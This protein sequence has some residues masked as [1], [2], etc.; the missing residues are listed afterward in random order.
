M[1][2]QQQYP[3]VRLPSRGSRAAPAGRDG[4]NVFQ[5]SRAP[6]VSSDNE[7]TDR[8]YAEASLT[9]AP[10]TCFRSL[11]VP[12]DGKRFGEHALPYA[13]GI[14]R[15]SGADIRLVHVHTPGAPP[16]SSDLL[17][18]GHGSGT[19]E[20]LQKQAYLND[21]CQ[22]VQ[23]ITPVRVTSLLVEGNDTAQSLYQV[24]SA[25]SDLVV[26]ASHGR[27]P[28]GRFCF[29]STGDALLQRLSVPVL[30]VR[31]Y[32]APV[33]LTGNPLLHHVL[34][35]LD[36]SE[37][38]E[39]VLDPALTLGALTGA[40]HTLIR[41]VRSSSDY[42][43]ESAGSVSET[44]LANQQR[45]DAWSYLQRV[46]DQRGG[47]M[48]RIHPRLVFDEQSTA[49]SILSFAE[50]HHADLI[51]LATSGRRGFE[52]LFRGSVADRVLRGATAPVLVINPSTGKVRRTIE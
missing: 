38:A 51:A 3:W 31:G 24:A 20:R 27:G 33:D 41:V 45:L 19:F 23:K 43:D 22:R 30:F 25:G 47:L 52:R 16:H 14:A 4:Q 17:Y 7:T 39:Q 40:E 8:A 32:K 29:G 46:A 18:Y 49:K 12:V 21:L 9:V 11:L 1:K 36:G 35:P 5:L 26:M 13:L 50:V 6:S 37:L 15:R 2:Y 10:S 44:Q 42:F 28:L 48:R 34:I